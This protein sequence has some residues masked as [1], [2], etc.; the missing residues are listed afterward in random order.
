MCANNIHVTE[1]RLITNKMI[2]APS[3]DSDQPGHLPSLIRVFA[4]RSMG[5]WGPTMGSWGPNV[6][7][8]I[9]W[10]LIRLGRCPGWSESSLGEKVILLDLSW[11]SSYY[12]LAR[13]HGCGSSWVFDGLLRDKYHF[14]HQDSWKPLKESGGIYEPRLEKTCFCH[15]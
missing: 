10:R 6:S 11:R 7:S 13:L 12:V 15:M 4:V 9:Q 5:S 8:C 14:S 1:P 2:C 3:E